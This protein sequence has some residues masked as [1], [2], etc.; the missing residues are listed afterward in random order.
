V[1]DVFV[2]A[3]RDAVAA[4]D[5]FARALRFGPVPVEVTSD[6]APV[7]PGSS[8]NSNHRLATSSSSTPTTLLKPIT[9]DSK[10][11]CARCVD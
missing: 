7:Y 1:I 4:R 5:F 6:R 3:R 10:R 8:R 9:A 2:S 11:D